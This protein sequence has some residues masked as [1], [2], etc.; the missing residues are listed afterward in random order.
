MHKILEKKTLRDKTVAEVMHPGCISIRSN[1]T[2]TDAIDKMR[3]A[4]VSSLIVEPRFEGDGYGIVT[5]RDVLAKAFVPG[6]KRMNFSERRVY[7]IM[8]KPFVT[9]PPHLKVK[10]AARLMTRENVHRMPVL[11]GTKIIGMLS[12]S[13]IFSKL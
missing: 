7:E 6:Q 3:K 9:V 8:T 10:Y 1:A 11:D 13:D 12:D 4:Q 2:L 5:R